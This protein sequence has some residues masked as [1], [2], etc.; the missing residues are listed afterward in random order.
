MNEGEA[1]SSLPRRKRVEATFYFTCGDFFHCKR[2]VFQ[3]IF[4]SFSFRMVRQFQLQI[5]VIDLMD[6][7]Q[8]FVEIALATVLWTFGRFLSFFS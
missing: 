2:Q 4:F 8:L 7:S 1:A 6:F 3:E 5:Y